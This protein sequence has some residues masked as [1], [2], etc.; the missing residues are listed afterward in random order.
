VSTE[1]PNWFQTAL[2]VRGSVLPII[3]PRIVLFGGI[4]GLV[5][6]MDYFGLP[7]YSKGLGDLTNNV[8]CNLVLG[9]LLVFRTNTAYERFWEG[10]RAWGMLVVNIRNLAREIQVGIA[11]PDAV[12][13]EDKQKV[14]NWLGVFAI[15]TKL[16]LRQQSIN[17]ELDPLTGTEVRSHLDQSHNPPL[18]LLLFISDYL[19]QQ[20]QQQRLDSSQR[21]LLTE[22]LNNLV[23]GVTNCERILTT[24]MPIAYS[25]YLKRLIII[26]CGLLPFSLVDEL[27]WWT[28]P[29]V[30]TI[31]FVLLG[32]EEIGNE[33]EDPFG[34]DP[35]D[36]P[37]DDICKAVLDSVESA[38]QFT[39]GSS[40]TVLLETASSNS[41][42]TTQIELSHSTSHHEPQET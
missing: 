31:S 19:Q 18:E 21:Y 32:I 4:G 16:H 20:C 2:T 9:L 35:N 12:S 27:H 10:R 11:E 36:L 34:T 14:L 3:L 33:I 1:K 41:H 29:I 26:Y 28:G 8:A 6:L 22:L 15:A 40:Q 24:P 7:F 37:L 25:V 13:R 38:K 17:D 23:E 30:A 42:P 5:S 39:L